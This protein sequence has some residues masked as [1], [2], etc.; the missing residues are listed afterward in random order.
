M[1]NDVVFLKFDDFDVYEI[2]VVIYDSYMLDDLKCL[3]KYFV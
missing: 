3:K 1:V 2:C